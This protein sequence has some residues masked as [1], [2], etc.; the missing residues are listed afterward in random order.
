MGE[1]PVSLVRSMFIASINTTGVIVPLEVGYVYGKSPDDHP[2]TYKIG[3][4]YDSSTVSDVDDPNRMVA[5]RTGGYIQAA[6]QVWK[7]H[8]ESLEG[9][10]VFAVATLSDPKTGTPCVR[11]A[12]RRVP[13]RSSS[14][15]IFS[16]LFEARLSTTRPPPLCRLRQ[17]LVR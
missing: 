9:L 1:P 2:G 12:V 5:G 6:Q 8:P 16:L 10:S 7:T 15:P 11:A 14:A 4:Y 17:S 13:I 3:A